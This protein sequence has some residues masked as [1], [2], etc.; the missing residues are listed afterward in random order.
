M[1]VV[2]VSPPATREP[3]ALST[4]KPSC[5]GTTIVTDW[6]IEDGSFLR[7]S[8]LTLGYTLPVT[9]TRKLGV[10]NLRVYATANNLFCWTAYSGQDPEVS[11]QRSTPLTPGVDYSA[12]PKAHSYV[13]GLN[14][15]F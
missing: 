1:A 12:Y 8:N 4:A 7:C 6:A 14:V 3:S 2:P 15:T 9:V 11:T 13:F 5:C 10:K